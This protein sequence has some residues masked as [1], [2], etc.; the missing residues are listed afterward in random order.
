VKKL[1]WL[2]VAMTWAACASDS[3]PVRIYN[4]SDLELAA[5]NA[6][7]MVCSCTFVMEM[8]EAFCAAWTKASP[9]VARYSVDK[10][11]KTVEASAFIS[12]T[13]KA[14]YVDDKRG[15]VLE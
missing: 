13:A 2:G 4:N 12:W 9:S 10:T 1:L 6:A 7:V 3:G 8:D 5:G 11:A 14:H 15:C